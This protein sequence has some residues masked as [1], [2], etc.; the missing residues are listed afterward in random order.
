M[1]IPTA[2]WNTFRCVQHCPPGRNQN[3]GLPRK[4]SRNDVKGM[5]TPVRLT[6]DSSLETHAMS[7]LKGTRKPIAR[8][9]KSPL[10]PSKI[11]SQSVGF[12]KRNGGYSYCGLF[13]HESWFTF[14]KHLEAFGHWPLDRPLEKFQNFGLREMMTNKYELEETRTQRI[15]EIVETWKSHG[16][17]N[18]IQCT[19]DGEGMRWGRTRRKVGTGFLCHGMFEMSKLNIF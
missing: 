15:T 9:L 11:W 2:L 4:N 10:C 5:P 17:K 16:K 7:S 6:C 18:T 13:L 14:R 12:S 8:L 3:Q 1:K 19:V